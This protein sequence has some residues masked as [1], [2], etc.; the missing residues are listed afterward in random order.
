MIKIIGTN[1]EEFRR[2]DFNIDKRHRLGNFD[3]IFTEGFSQEGFQELVQFV[4][5]GLPA[6]PELR[7]NVREDMH[8][9]PEPKKL[10]SVDEEVTYLDDEVS[11]KVME[12]MEEA[13]NKEAGDG[14]AYPLEF[15]G[16]RIAEGQETR[17]DYI[18]FMR[19]IR[20]MDFE[21]D[22]G[23]SSYAA[24]SEE[25]FNTL[26][27]DMGAV[28]ENDVDPRKIDEELDIEEAFHRGLD[29]YEI[30]LEDYVD[31][32][33]EKRE[34]FQDQRDQEWYEQITSQIN[35]EDRVLI[36]TGIQHALETEDTVA[37]LLSQD[38]NV[39]VAPYHND[40]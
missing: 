30:S 1:H 3:K 31:V 40:W 34:D 15:L 9:G 37:G 27:D 16:E 7:A 20:D 8:R 4:M 28:M 10:D 2:N 29:R 19:K 38:Y 12:G 23:Y 13:S 33:A 26:M 32:Q 39:D 22:G 14:D 35:D 6:D 36:V 25:G 5:N 11:D 21:E 18:E 24:L 17:D